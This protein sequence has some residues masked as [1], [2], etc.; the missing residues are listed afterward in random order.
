MFPIGS[1]IYLKRLE[2]AITQNE[3]AI[4][5]GIPQSNLSNIERGKC[6]MTVSMLRRIAVAL[7][8]APTYFFADFDDES[9]K[10]EL[11]RNEIEKIA[12]IV[13]KGAEPSTSKQREITEL[14]KKVIPHSGR[15]RMKNLN[16]SWLELR[17]RFSAAEISS[18]YE[19]VEEYRRRNK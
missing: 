12:K 6:D 4:L 15:K 8:V 11:S 13:A 3:L 17:K 14:V 19:R 2:K 9:G 7:D 18:I 10:K 5:A 16:R 1:H